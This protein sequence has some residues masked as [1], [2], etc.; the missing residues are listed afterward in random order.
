VLTFVA[1]PRPAVITT[2]TRAGNVSAVQFTT[3]VGNQYALS[4]TNA[5]GGP[6]STWPVDG[7]FVVGNGKLNTLN[8]T[9]TDNA[10]FYR[11]NTQ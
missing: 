10:E 7:G 11:V 2:F 6:V 4:F 5:L 3:T 9:N 8:R 1:G